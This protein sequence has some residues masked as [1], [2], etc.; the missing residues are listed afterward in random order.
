MLIFVKTVSGKTFP[1][2]TSPSETI[3]DLKQRI[4]QQAGLPS[5]LVRV[6]CNGEALNEQN[7]VSVLSNESELHLEWDAEGGKKKNCADPFVIA[8]AQEKSQVRICV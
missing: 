4:L 1:I 3:S 6:W 2:S 7:Y 8:L 5:E